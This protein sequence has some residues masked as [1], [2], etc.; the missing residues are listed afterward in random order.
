[1]GANF[2]CAECSAAGVEFVKV[3]VLI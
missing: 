2:D 3:D 1:L